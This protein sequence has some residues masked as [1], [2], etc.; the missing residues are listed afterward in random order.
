MITDIGVSIVAFAT[1]NLKTMQWLT[2]IYL[3]IS[4]CDRFIDVTGIDFKHNDTMELTN[5]N[6]IW[7]IT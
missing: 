5:K 3:Y 4:R 2:L 1:E 6:T 7:K